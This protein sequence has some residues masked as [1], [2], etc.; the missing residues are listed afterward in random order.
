M[1]DMKH[2]LTTLSA[3]LI[4]AS[5]SF[6]QTSWLDHAAD[7][8]AGGSGTQ[9]DPY[10]IATPEQL[11]KLAADTYGS[12]A[13]VM[14][15]KENYTIYEAFEGVYFRLTADIDLSGH[16]WQGIGGYMELPVEDE[17]VD[18][19]YDEYRF[20]GV[21]DGDG[22]KITNMEGLYGFVGSTGL[23]AEVR[24]VTVESGEITAYGAIT[25]AGGIVGAN[26]G[27]VENCVNKANVTAFFFY[28]GGVVGSN[29]TGEDGSPSGIVRKCINLGRVSSRPDIGNGAY[30]GGICGTNTS[31]IE[32]CANYGDVSATTMGSA[33]IACMVD[34]GVVRNCYNRGSIT[35]DAEQAGGIAAAVM[36]RSGEAEVY[37]CYN[38]G[39]VYCPLGAASCVVAA[40]NINQSSIAL[41]HLYND[42][43]ACPGLYVVGMNVDSDVD[44]ATTIDIEP[45]MMKSQAF[46]NILNKAGET[47]EWIVDET[48][49]DGYP[50]F[51]SFRDFLAESGVGLAEQVAGDAL[52]DIS[53]YA[54]DG[55]IVVT[56]AEEAEITV[57]GTA[58]TVLARGSR[59][60]VSAMTFDGGI[61]VVSVRSG[62][63][64][65]NVKVAI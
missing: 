29:E 43:Q 62:S 1:K 19:D 12:A 33:G 41:H 61:Y 22:K 9:A 27:L 17:N 10:L 56:G 49:N 59:E 35:C 14:E 18:P 44:E 7:S 58:G 55:H 32:L 21:I 53:V 45:A 5:A 39:E 8:Y 24:N 37:A 63:E 50:T 20:M 25:M 34:A 26:R 36:G 57:Y 11:A 13:S 28:P 47:D 48:V 54:I 30:S 65:R 60:A 51:A 4:A 46:V 38:A 31:I 6:A 64:V 40:M 16:E 52:S 23:Y 2:L 42:A 3:M 15:Q